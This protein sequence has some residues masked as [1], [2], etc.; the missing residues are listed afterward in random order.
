[1][2]VLLAWECTPENMSDVSSFGEAL[3][4]M[5]DLQGQVTDK[6]PSTITSALNA[7]E[8]AFECLVKDH[9]LNRLV[10]DGLAGRVSIVVHGHS[11]QMQLC[12][13]AAQAR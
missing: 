4:A 11:G 10:S 13:A 1:M 12:N 8:L 5:Q 9:L 2:D 7:H 6:T 3:N